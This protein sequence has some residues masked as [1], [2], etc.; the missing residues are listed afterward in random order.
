M[1]YV[2]VP[3]DVLLAIDETCPVC[4]SCVANRHE[5]PQPWPMQLYLER[6]VL[7]DPTFGTGYEA[8]V[9]RRE[10][11]NQFAKAAAG[12]WVN[13]K[14]DHWAILVS[15]IQQPQGAGIPNQI[16]V[17]FIPLMEAVLQAKNTKPTDESA[18]R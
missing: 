10:I 11:E 15:T 13:V 14:D 3:E 4:Q 5:S 2:L 1:R 12:D 16:L 8:L 7:R 18:N 17:Q 9:A 6:V